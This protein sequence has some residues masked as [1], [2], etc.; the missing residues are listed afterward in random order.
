[1]EGLAVVVS[2]AELNA[3]KH[4]GSP[5]QQL[6]AL[7]PALDRL[8]RLLDWAVKAMQSAQGAEA[9][10]P[11]RGLFISREEAARLLSQQP[12]ATPF[13]LKRRA[14]EDDG[15]V[16][17][18]G[19][20]LAWIMRAFG[21]TSFDLDVVLLALAPEFDLRYEKLFAYLQDDVT[22]RRPTV[23]LA[24]NLLCSS[25]DAKL[26]RRIHFSPSAPLIRHGLLHLVP[27][28]NQVEP[29][30]LARY[31]KLDD[32]ITRLLLGEAGLDPRLAS[33]SE[34]IEPSI[35]W[36]QL[37]LRPEIKNVL[38]YLTAQAF[39]THQPLRLYF[40]GPCGAGK[41]RVAEALA[42][43]VGTRLL[44]VRLDRLAERSS[45]DQH[46]KLLLRDARIADAIIYV[47]DLDDFRGPEAAIHRQD[48]LDALSGHQG[49][50]IL[51]G[52]HTWVPRVTA[53]F[54]VIP[55]PFEIPEF[56]ERYTSWR[57]QLANLGIQLDAEELEALASRFRLTAG[58]ITE[59]VATA[60]LSSQWR[61]AKS[62]SRDN[63]KST[64]TPVVP[65]LDDLFAAARAQSGHDLAA[66]AHKIEPR[67]DWNDIVLPDD[68]MT[69]L[70]EICSQAQ[71]RH[72]VYGIWGFDRKLSLGKGLNVLFS[73][74]PGTG[75]TMAAEVIASELH[76]D[77]YRIDLSQII[78][79]YIGET[80][81]NLD[82]IFTAAENS[83]TILFFDEADA[84]FGKRSEVRDSHDRY[85]NIEISYLLQ[86]MEE[87]QGVSIL[88]TNLR[89]NLDDAFVR[90]LQ[91]IVEFPFPDE[92]Y[93][94]RIWEA[95]FPKEAPLG[96]DVRFELL[97]HEVHLAG[98]NIKNMALAAAFYAA[99]DGGV[100]RMGHLIQAGHREYQKLGR[101]W[102]EAELCKAKAAAS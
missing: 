100:I 57:T 87:Y 35:D 93:R 28:P 26:D 64:T 73:G 21:L 86:K 15:E 65:S 37:P 68:P 40:Q 17:L 70:R 102:N 90:R 36:E 16:S 62:T 72:V 38:P 32:Q 96:E 5:N 50:T 56:V 44:A 76:L 47:S 81:K 41:R 60:L 11:F 22:R 18:E 83:N 1:M 34:L 97:A 59:A 31:L 46:W 2:P 25:A 55:V 39:A 27:D 23:E 66:L 69:Q 79:K 85:A 43:A 3:S 58:Q 77:L 42:S 7:L 88:A 78:N 8:D 98:G 48:L 53:A 49:V 14:L 101:M 89:Q 9:S 80:E 82:R 30:F 24:L 13:A 45:P 20:P 6:S 33:F 99:A 19:S 74:P 67:Y 54:A 84:L 94:R 92:E 91:A 71:Y 52:K 4:S 75:K 12:G 63:V 29:S 95:V 61:A 10:A 51:A